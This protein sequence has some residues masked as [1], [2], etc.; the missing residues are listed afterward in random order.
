LNYGRLEQ[1][2]P[3]RELYDEPATEFVMTFVGDANVVD[4]KLARPHELD[5]SPE[6]PE[7]SIEA[8]IVRVT[9]LGRDANVELHDETGAEIVARSRGI[10]SRSSIS[11]RGQTVWLRPQRELVFAT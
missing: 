8:M 2:G 9:I 6:P 1:V 3:P 11:G 10:N 4:G 5:L 7:R